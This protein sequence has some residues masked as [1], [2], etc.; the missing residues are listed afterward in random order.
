[1]TEEELKNFSD[2]IIWGL[3]NEIILV[4]NSG[5][6]SATAIMTYVAIDTM[7]YLSMP[8]DKVKNESSDFI[9][10][11]DT[12]LKTDANQ[13]YKYIGK[14]MW[15]ARCSILHSYS[16]TSGYTTK[17]GC[18]KYVYH[19]N[20]NHEYDPEINKKLVIISIELLVKDFGSAIKDF[21]KAIHK[22]HDL[23]ER[24]ASR[25]KNVFGQFPL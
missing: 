15:R 1:M 20:P 4:R 25:M 22:D 12:Y 23:N 8:L 2:K 16:V 18:K 3:F 6:I 13:P 14:D 10:W 11:V 21:L 17:Q 24:V 5:C 9:E 19:N 7:A